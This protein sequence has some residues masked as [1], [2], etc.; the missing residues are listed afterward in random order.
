MGADHED[1][2]KGRGR[3]GLEGASTVK[4]AAGLVA[5]KLQKLRSGGEKLFF[6][7]FSFNFV[8]LYY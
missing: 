5:L 8:F 7:H 2:H 6:F 1:Y 3:G 4:Q